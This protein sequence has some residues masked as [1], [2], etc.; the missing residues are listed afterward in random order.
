MNTLT[1]KLQKALKK[2]Q[3]KA[4]GDRLIEIIRDSLIDK[5]CGPKGDPER[6]N[7][8]EYFSPFISTTI[9]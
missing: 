9:H 7:E 2:R 8:G 1:K 3:F 6:Y 5:Y 4:D